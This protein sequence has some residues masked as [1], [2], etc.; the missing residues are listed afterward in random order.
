MWDTSQLPLSGNFSLSKIARNLLAVIVAALLLTIFHSTVTHAAD[1]NWQDDGSIVY[2]DKTYRP[3][4]PPPQGAVVPDG[5]SV[6][7]ARDSD[8][9]PTANVLYIEA[10]SDPTKEMRAKVAEYTVTNTGEF[11]NARPPTD[12][13][14]AAKPDAKNKTQ[15][16]VAGIGWIICTTSKFIAEGMDKIFDLIANYLEV[17]PISTD[18]DSGTYKAWSVALSIANLM[19]ILAFLAII[20]AHITSAGMSNY[21]IKKMIPKLIIAAILVNISYYICA[22]AVDASNILGYS[23]QEALIE[24]R[25]SLPDPISGIT[26]SNMTTF[27]LSSGTLAAGSVG[28][29]V[30]LSSVGGFAG[31]PFVLFPILVA[32]ALAVLVALIVLAARQAIIIVLIVVAPLAFVAYILPNTEKWFEKWRDLFTTMLLVFP[33]FSL[34]F[35]GSQLASYIVIQ[36]TNQISVV[37]FAMFIQVAPLVLTPFLVKFSGSLLGRLAGMINDPKKGLVD[38]AR[39]FSQERGDIRKAGMVSRGST[40]RFGLARMAYRREMGRRNRAGMKSTYENEADAAWHNDKRYHAQHRRDKVSSLRKAVGES[41]GDVEFERYVNNPSSRTIRQYVGR[42]MVNDEV[43]KS[44]QDERTAAF[45]EAKSASMRD[46]N[47]FAQYSGEAKSAVR[48]QRVLQ[49]NITMAQSKVKSEYSNDLSTDA[50]LQLR[51]GGIGGAQGAIKVK[52]AAIADVVNSGN[53][54]VNAIKTASDIKAGDVDAMEAE[55][56]KA[57]RNKDIASM[58]AHTDMLAE[59]ADVGMNRLRQVLD[60]DDSEIRAVGPDLLDVYRHHINGNS[61]INA[62]AED[63]AVW[64]RDIGNGYRKISEIG[65]SGDTWKN[66]TASQ[67]ASSK[68]STQTIAL[69]AKKADGTWAVSKE[70]AADIVKSTAWVSIKDEMKPAFLERAE[71]TNRFDIRGG[72]S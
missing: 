9:S 46:D 72:G 31:L 6:F 13:S 17:K 33:L 14:L 62:Q 50:A 56:R 42:K 60:K 28:A 52:A 34:L 25:K 70:M 21:N 44:L 51:A 8:T 10:N 5:A 35:G 61:G 38:R 2:G 32:G 63:I 11:T 54:A 30:G 48:A 43:V 37:I 68:K 65:N 40:Q 15:C 36:N 64:S 24:I 45:E 67:I 3:T 1:A 59:S 47:M 18:T 66:L 41:N 71:I 20:Y 27:I 22:I 55:L 16:D 58:R 49:D 4:S 23:V 19:F 26:W 29:I 53:E 12:I 57:I 7:V 39:N 69:K